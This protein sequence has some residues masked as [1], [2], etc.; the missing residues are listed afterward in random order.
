MADVGPEYEE[1]S[2]E[3]MLEAALQRDEEPDEDPVD[4]VADSGEL[5]VEDPEEVRL[6]RVR[7]LEAAAQDAEDDS[8]E[9]DLM[10]ALNS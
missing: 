5:I 7:R 2:L 8:L 9:A 10:R 6:E 3:A 1:G 4:D